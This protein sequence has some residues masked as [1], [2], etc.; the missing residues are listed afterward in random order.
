MATVATRDVM[1]ILREIRIIGFD[2]QRF[3]SA[4]KDP[5]VFQGTIRYAD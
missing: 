4:L 2:I 3:L 1:V 5:G